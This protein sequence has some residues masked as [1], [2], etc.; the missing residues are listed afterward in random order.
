MT[1][2]E[3]NKAK[4]KVQNG[5]DHNEIKEKVEMNDMKQ[6]QKTNDKNKANNSTRDEY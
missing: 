4:D 6:V 3:Y 1:K 5:Q 2:N